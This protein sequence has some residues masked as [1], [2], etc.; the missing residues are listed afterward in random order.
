MKTL[1]CR[2]GAGAFWIAPVPGIFEREGRKALKRRQRTG[3]CRT[4]RLVRGEALP[5]CPCLTGVQR[6]VVSPNSTL[7]CCPCPLRVSISGREHPRMLAP[8]SCPALASR[9]VVA[10]RLRSSPNAVRLKAA[11]PQVVQFDLFAFV[12]VECVACGAR[13]CTEF[14]KHVAYYGIP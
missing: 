3:N 10:P 11:R 12:G 13:V 9:A 2:K 4:K 1:I 7:V 14:Q 6:R 5:N 8:V